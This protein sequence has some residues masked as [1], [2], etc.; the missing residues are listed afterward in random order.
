MIEISDK[1]YKEFVKWCKKRVSQLG[2]KNWKI[3]YDKLPMTDYAQTS[4][5][6]I[7]MTATIAL[8]KEMNEINHEA[9]ELKDTAYHE[10]FH[11]LLAKLVHLATS[12]YATEEEI[13]R[14]EEEIVISLCNMEKAERKVKLK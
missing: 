13:L 9:L 4:K 12:R 14:A 5:D 3:Y 2:L 7:G 11:L 8:A 10:V 6:P 1:E